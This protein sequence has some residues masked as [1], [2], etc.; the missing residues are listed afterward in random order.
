MKF[1]RHGGTLSLK[2]AEIISIL[3][4]L[5]LYF[6]I[7]SLL[8]LP[9][10]DEK[11][12][13]TVI[14]GLATVAGILTAFVGFWSVYMFSKFK[15]ERSNE[16]LVSRMPRMLIVLFLGLLIVVL[17]LV[18]MVYGNQQ[19][20]FAISLFGSALIIIVSIDVLLI[21]GFSRYKETS[22]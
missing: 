2:E 21:L 5:A 8:S 16:F 11:Y 12:V 9:T 1:D 6:L 13:P 20:A 4:I 7:I 10:F 3:A 15:D 17:G 14:T 18:L 19:A 22:N